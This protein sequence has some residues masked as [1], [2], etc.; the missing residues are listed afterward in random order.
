MH[1]H[2]LTVIFLC[3]LTPMAHACGADTDCRIADRTYRIH[4]GD[5]LGPHPGALI[6]AHGYKGSAAGVMRNG[7]LRRMADE[8]GV[9]LIALQG[10]DGMWGLANAPGGRVVDQPS[11]LSYVDAVVA[12][13]TERFGIDSEK[14]VATGF[15]AG[16]MMAWTLACHRSALFAGF[17]PVS[18]TFWAPV[19]ETCPSPAQNLIHIHGD[20]DPVVPLM[21]RPIAR[22]KQGEVPYAL[23]M[24]AKHGGFSG[25]AIY[26]EADMSCSEQRNAHGALLAFCEFPGGHSFSVERLR[27]AWERIMR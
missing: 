13:V 10:V 17:I 23:D 25:E 4:L 3:L 21:G 2:I 7:F 19:P 22:T 9:A 8:L 15:S 18:G 16:G 24:Y 12:D 6:Y 5:D 11:E 20:D 14:L 26:T 1:R 27:L